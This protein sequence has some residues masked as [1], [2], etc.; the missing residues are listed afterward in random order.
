[1]EV[2][3]A[4]SWRLFYGVPVP[5]LRLGIPDVF[6]LTGSWEEIYRHFGLDVASIV[7]AVRSF[8]VVD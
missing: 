6:G 4:L 5:V 8:F 7:Q 1:M 2:W 3:G